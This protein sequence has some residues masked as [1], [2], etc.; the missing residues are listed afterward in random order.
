MAT[1]VAP[2][3]GS[4]ASPTL[5]S[6]KRPLRTTAGTESRNEKRAAATR[7]NP[8]TALGDRRRDRET[9]DRRQRLGDAH[10]EAVAGVH[11]LDRAAAAAEMLG[12]ASEE[13]RISAE[14]IR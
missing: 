1:I 6:S 11:V 2:T 14:P 9:P 5:R 7:S 12:E 13:K 10:E 8:G 4:P 3:G